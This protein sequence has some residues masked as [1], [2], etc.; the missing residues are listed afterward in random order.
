MGNEQS[1]LEPVKEESE[2]ERKESS[3]EPPP[4]LSEDPYQA[5]GVSPGCSIEEITSAY[6][7]LIPI[8]HPDKNHSENAKGMFVK[9]HRA[10]DHVMFFEGKKASGSYYCGESKAEETRRKMQEEAERLKLERIERGKDHNKRIEHFRRIREAEDRRQE[11][12]A[13]DRKSKE[14][15]RRKE[16]TNRKQNVQAEIEAKIERKIRQ[17]T[18]SKF[19]EIKAEVE[20]LKQ[21]MNNRKNVIQTKD[22]PIYH[23]VELTLQEVFDGCTRT[24]TH[25]K[26][27]YDTS[28]VPLRR[29]STDFPL[30]FPR[31]VHEGY[32]VK[33]TAEGD[34]HPGTI[35]A[36]VHYVVRYKAH[37]YFR[38]EGKR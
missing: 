26:H 23:T 19:R 27:I 14:F 36:D 28:G 11:A 33:F 12:E 10:Y 8:Y 30:R 35:P 20:M 1:M 32:E 21:E 6:R 7:K 9:L 17:E 29:E 22:K 4:S 16:E 5:L 18:E 15:Q 3:T 25:C 37:Q 38:R 34:Q 24:M 31:S 13:F 2:S